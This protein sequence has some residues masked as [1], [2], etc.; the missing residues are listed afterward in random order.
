MSGEG[1]ARLGE[2]IRVFATLGLTGFGG[3]AAHIALLERECVTNRAWISREEFLD[4]LGAANLLPGPTSTELALLL[5]RKRAGLPGLFAAGAC[6]VGPATLLVCALAAGYVRG[7]ALPEVRGASR[8]LTPVV[9]AILLQ[10]LAVLGRSALRG[11][12]AWVIAA[13]ALG[14]AA[15]GIHPLAVL[16]LAA[17]ANGV[18]ARAAG[19]VRALAPF[20]PLA[21]V[22]AAAAVPYSGATLFAT[23]LT[24]GASLYGSGYALFAFLRADFVTRLGWLDERTLL[25][26]FAAGQATPGPVFTTATFVGWV[27]DGPRGAL[28]ATLA[29][30]TP[31]F[32]FA[33]L[34]GPLVERARRSDAARAWLAGATLGS[35]GLL[36]AS[37][38]PLGAAALA[39]PAPIAVFALAV[40]LLLRGVNAMWPLLGAALAG[41]A[42]G[43]WF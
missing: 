7:A 41:A 28:L 21:V 37:A 27:L 29:I 35:L 30:F 23:L 39:H 4:L 18:A 11:T 12:R 32:V 5:G 2:V 43:R 9:L 36:A 40:V 10:A 20:A 24:T 33:A 26:A 14:A 42:F 17:A 3:P 6:F 1:G 34:A 8:M 25:D 19:G 31:A 38:L 22:G 15:A 13:C 16:L